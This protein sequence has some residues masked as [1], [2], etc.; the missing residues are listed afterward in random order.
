MDSIEQVLRREWCEVLG[1]TQV[2]DDDEFLA[3]GGDSKAAVALI[4]RVRRHGD[5]EFPLDVLFLDGTFAGILAA[6][7]ALNAGK[8]P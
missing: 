3:S 7:R 2:N 4:Q 1:V 5:I 6:C 8:P